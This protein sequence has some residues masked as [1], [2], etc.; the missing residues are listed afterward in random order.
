[1]CLN[2]IS[3]RYLCRPVVIPQTRKAAA[4]GLLTSE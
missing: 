3:G 4:A 2:H 1:L